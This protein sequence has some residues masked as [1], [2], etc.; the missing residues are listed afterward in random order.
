MSK[1][2]S[3]WRFPADFRPRLFVVRVGLPLMCIVD[4][5]GYRLLAETLLPIDHQ[6]DTTL[7]YGSRDGGATIFKRHEPFANSVDACARRLNLKPHKLKQSVL[8]LTRVTR[9]TRAEELD[10][11]DPDPGALVEMSVC[12]DLEGHV[13]LDGRCVRPR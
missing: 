6:G 11:G 13:G 5:L 4:F 7:V 8:T 10:P 3:P 2:Q 12:A 1:N 9:V